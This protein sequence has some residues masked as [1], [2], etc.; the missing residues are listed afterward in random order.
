MSMMRI[1]VTDLTRMRGTDVCVAGVTL[2]PPVRCIRPLLSQGPGSPTRHPD[3]RWLRSSIGRPVRL[4]SLLSLDVF[5]HR[6]S[7]PHVEDTAVSGRSPTVESVLDSSAR[8]TLLASIEQWAVDDL[9][10]APIQWSPRTDGRRSGGWVQPG[11]GLASL[12]T[13]RAGIERFEI[14]AKT[15]GSTDYRVWFRDQA[16]T[17]NRLSITDLSFRYWV[18]SLVRKFGGS[19]QETNRT[20]GTVFQ[21]DR[22]VWLRIGLTRPYRVPDRE[23]ECCY[24]Q[25]TGIHTIPDYLDGATWYELQRPASM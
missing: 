6:P 7:P 23:T 8:R 24:L 19:F 25:V 18:D 4:F 5:D 3:E 16:G 17:S 2:E 14:S 10:G 20:L 11:T 15:D 21:R 12:G 22:E 9:F 13:L 1:V